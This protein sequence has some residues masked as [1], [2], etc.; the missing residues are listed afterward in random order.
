MV[1]SKIYRIPTS[2]QIV[3]HCGD[4]F[5]GMRELEAESVSLIVTSPPY[6]LGIN[7]HSYDDS[8]SRDAYLD[9]I[10]TWA[11]LAVA[12]LAEDGSLFLNVGSSPKDP[13]IGMDVARRVSRHMLLQNTIHWIKSISIDH[14]AGNGIE[15]NPE[16][17]SYGHFKPIQSPRFLNDCHEFIFHFTR[18]GCVPIDRKAIGVPYTHKSN[19]TRWKSAGEDR[20]CR[21]NAWFIPYKTIWSR[22]RQRPHPASFPEELV[23]KCIRLQGISRIRQVLDPFSGIGTTPLV[24]ARFG[25]NCIGYE[26]DPEYYAVGRDRLDEYFSVAPGK[27]RQLEIPT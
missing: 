14:P 22:E 24:C 2:G 4:C 16:P 15:C 8:I 20:R 17:V 3:I 21:G 7:Y 18:T 6:N 25:L 1:D 26:I 11:Q 10:D 13:F 19:I 27:L 23:E 12:V 5:Q 9:W